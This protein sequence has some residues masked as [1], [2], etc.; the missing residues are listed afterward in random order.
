MDEQILKQ[1]ATKSGIENLVTRDEFRQSQSEIYSR[2]DEIITVVRRLDQE[3]VFTFEYVRRVESEVEK[4]RR[5]I[6]RIKD[7]LKIG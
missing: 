4:N 2:L 5:D 1:L 6:D 3:R 7:I